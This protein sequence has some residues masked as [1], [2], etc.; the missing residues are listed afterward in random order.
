MVMLYKF[1][2]SCDTDKPSGA[3]LINTN[4]ESAFELETTNNFVL[5]P[6]PNNGT[7]QVLYSLIESMQATIIVYD[8]A[9]KQ[10]YAKQLDA[11]T[12]LIQLNLDNLSN[13]VYHYQIINHKQEV[14]KS[15]K[16]II[17]K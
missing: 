7:M 13:G 4:D 12:N 6:N 1:T 8:V 17:I 2:D 16:L 9:G 14:L 11:N 10:V 3:R 5:F 15:D